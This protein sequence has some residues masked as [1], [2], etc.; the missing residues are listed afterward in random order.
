[1]LFSVL[2]MDVFDFDNVK[3]EKANAMLRYRRR[4]IFK[5]MFRFLE[6]C[7]ALVF[8]SYISTR[9]PFVVKVSGEYF[10]Q[11]ISIISKPVFV[12]IISNVIILTLFL[13][14][15]RNP[16]GENTETEL[17]GDLVEKSEAR[18]KFRSENQNLVKEIEEIVYQD[19]Q[20][21]SEKNANANAN[22]CGKSGDEEE[23]VMI[24]TKSEADSSTEMKVYRR[25]K[26]EKLKHEGD[27]K[28]VGVLRRSETEM[29][30]KIVNRGGEKL[31]EE[32]RGVEK[33]SNEDFQRTIEA[34]IEKQVSFHL[35]EKFTVVPFENQN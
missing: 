12:F 22:I 15:G 1:M 29:C 25:S 20:V 4:R 7:L 34:F 16:I 13:K 8:L 32:F 18:T 3:V 26:S 24:V 11:L 27:E 28:A 6:F 31:E 5:N 30:R 35:Q 21:I 14:S 23:L 17:Y 10:R 33:L 2:Q 9:L 19:K